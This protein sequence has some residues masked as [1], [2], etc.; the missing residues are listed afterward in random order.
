MDAKPPWKGVSRSHIPESEPPA[1]ALGPK[2]FDRWLARGL[3]RLYGDAGE[4]LPRDLL[5][6][7]ARHQKGP[8]PD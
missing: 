4:P 2:A 5:D 6:L 3:K 8:K 7:L 1:D